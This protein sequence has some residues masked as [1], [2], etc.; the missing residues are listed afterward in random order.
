MTGLTYGGDF[1]GAYGGDQGGQ[2]GYLQ[3]GP[4]LDLSL[5]GAI[6][7]AVSTDAILSIDINREHT[8]LSDMSVDIPPFEGIDANTYT[9]GEMAY[10]LDGRLIF[11]AEIDDVSVGNDKTI[12]IS[13]IAG[14]DQPLTHNEY[15][16]EF[17]ETL[18]EDAIELF[19]NAVLPYESV[20]YPTPDRPLN[21]K[22]VQSMSSSGDF[23]E[24]LKTGD[25]V[26]DDRSLVRELPESTRA[27]LPPDYIPTLHATSPIQILDSGLTTTQTT[28]FVEAEDASLDAPI[29]NRSDLSEEQ[30]VRIGRPDHSL[31]AQFAF[32]HDIPEGWFDVAFRARTTYVGSEPFDRLEFSLDGQTLATRKTS[33]FIN[34]G[35]DFRWYRGQFSYDNTLNA[36][37]VTEGDDP[38]ELTITKVEGDDDIVFDCFAFYDARFGFSAS[39]TEQVDS[40]NALSGPQLYPFQLPVVFDSAAIGADV[41][42]IDWVVDFDEPATYGVPG[43]SIP[44]T[45]ETPNGGV[46]TD[47]EEVTVS[48]AHDIP[49]ETTATTVYGVVFL[50][51]YSDPDRSVSPTENTNSQILEAAE[52]HID[53]REVSVIADGRQF[54]GTPLSILQE[55]HTH[56]NRRFVVEHGVSDP[57][58]ARFESFV[59]GDQSVIAGDSNRWIITDASRETTDEGDAN[60]V[61]VVGAR[62]PDGTYYQGVARDDA[63]IAQLDEETPDGDDGVRPVQVTDRSLTSDNDCL[64]RARTELQERSRMSIGGDI[65]TTPMLPAPGYPYRVRV[66]DAEGFTDEEIGYGLNYGQY[67]GAGSLGIVSSLETTAYSESASE[68]GTSLAFERPSGLFRAIKETA[69]ADLDERPHPARADVPVVSSSEA[70]PAPPEDTDD[71][72][73]GTEPPPDDGGT[74][75][76]AA[77]TIDDSTVSPG[78]TVTFDASQSTDSD[79][80]IQSYQWDFGDG[81]TAT[82][83]SVTHSYSADG[84][85]TVTLTVSDD[86][87]IFD[88]ATDTV[89]VSSGTEE[90]IAYLSNDPLSDADYRVGGSAGD[91]THGG[92]H[93]TRP[94][95]MPTKSEADYV[96]RTGHGLKDALQQGG[97]GVIIYIEDDADISNFNDISVPNGCKLVGGFCDPEIPGRGPVLFNHDDPPYKRHHLRADG[98]IECWGVSFEGP[99]QEYFDPREAP[100]DASDY[101]SNALF[102]YGTNSNGREGADVFLY[103]CEFRGWGI[104]GLELGARNTPSV[105]HIERCT[106]INN[107][108]ETYGYGV[109]QYDGP[110]E[111]SWCY[112]N[113]N[114]HDFSGFGYYSES[115]YFHDNMHGTTVLSHAYDMHGLNQ[116][117]SGA[118]NNAGKFTRVERCTFPFLEDDRPDY[119]S[120]Q[121]GVTIR[122]IPEEESW[123][124]DCHF[125]HSGPPAGDGPGVNG[126]PFRQ[127]NIDQNHFVNFTYRGNNYGE[128]LEDG[129]GCPLNAP[130]K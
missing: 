80:T 30:G 123:V 94:T 102:A 128:K 75:P 22:L 87:G 112:S 110:C 50:D 109:E 47:Q 51:N 57:S 84:T 81:N 65:E 76:T 108:M 89:S 17:E 16:V 49:E 92:H 98:Y 33:T 70:F 97:P 114:R 4:R 79:G 23:A 85:Y 39:L 61:R 105:G 72:D 3:R 20:V 21:N 67:Y 31:T 77:F 96:I 24:F 44:A 54:Q 41:S 36:A 111:V 27:F 117:L 60:Q 42:H 48:L 28:I 29:S 38:H 104:A 6:G 1:G 25:E 58:D 119:Y 45:G 56:A 107:P 59:T 88:S 68:A 63:A 12:T 35:S 86:D 100:G 66:F 83:Q 118:P 53:G 99:Q 34:Y 18:T 90:A 78:D 82:G 101:Y 37:N 40:N 95:A 116:N 121:E 9:G 127:D 106:F 10:H 113:N 71:S 124:R 93:V 13:G 115:W 11:T 129:K 64:S 69:S 19:A 26:E 46:L 62:A 130:V 7:S 122:G 74:A 32:V 126:D 125:Y 14:E 43:I 8:A 15:D 91:G 55:L 5:P 52:M 73:D 120:D 2:Y 103:G